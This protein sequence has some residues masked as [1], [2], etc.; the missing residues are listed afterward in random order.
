M[1]IAYHRSYLFR[2]R[3]KKENRALYNKLKKIFYNKVQ[4]FPSGLG[5]EEL[6]K[7]IFAGYTLKP[8]R[9]RILTKLDNETLTV[10]QKKL[11]NPTVEGSLKGK[12]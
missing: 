11:L 2:K 9:D 4:N 6:I 7:E 8:I 1:L 3:N 5:M 12:R 10:V